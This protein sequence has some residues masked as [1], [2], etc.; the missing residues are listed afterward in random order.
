LDKQ[1]ALFED[2]A[3]APQ[4]LKYCADFIRP[5]EERELIARISELPL[6]PFQF[7]QFQGKRRVVS[8]GWRYDYSAHR[9]LRTDD[10]PEWLA[11]IAQRIE[12][13]GGA[14]TVIGQILC[15]EYESG[16]GIGWHR[17]KPQ[18]DRIFGLSLGSNCKLRF[19]RSNGSGWERFAL[20]VAPRSIYMMAG[21]ARSF[22]EH[23]IPPVEALRYSVTFRTMRSESHS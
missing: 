16:V 9:A 22:W 5:E 1:L 23:S 6:E 15:T 21:P 18:F 4:G 3:R 19:R 2:D 20:E 8:F 13:F 14:D 10:P 7:G 17:D 11:P 12:T